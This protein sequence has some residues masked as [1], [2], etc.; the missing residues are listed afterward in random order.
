MQIILP[1]FCTAQ[2]STK[3]L[4]EIKN[5]KTKANSILIANTKIT[6]L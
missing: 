1:W 4:K 3:Y 5:V 6:L 2:W